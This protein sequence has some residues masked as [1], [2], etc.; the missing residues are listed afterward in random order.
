MC[1]DTLKQE[2]LTWKPLHLK[3]IQPS[4]E[5][6]TFQQESNVCKD[7]TEMAVSSPSLREDKVGVISPLFTSNTTYY[8]LLEED[9][10]LRQPCIVGQP[11]NT[12]DHGLYLKE[13]TA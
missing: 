10:M 11:A 13:M 7:E 3:L 12:E 6:A 4:L 8:F 9:F 2:H 5:T 1:R